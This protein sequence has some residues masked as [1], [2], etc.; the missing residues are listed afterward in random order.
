MYCYHCR[1]N[2]KIE[3][4]FINTEQLLFK[5]SVL[6]EWRHNPDKTIENENTFFMVQSVRYLYK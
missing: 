4:S 6:L 5:L 2:F 3:I 1:I